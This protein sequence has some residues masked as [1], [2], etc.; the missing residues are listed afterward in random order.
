MTELDTH[1]LAL[2]EERADGL[3]EAL[4]IMAPSR[5]VALAKT[6]VDEALLWAREHA[7]PK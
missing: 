4:A 2:V 1:W 7:R 6:K 3:R 5:E